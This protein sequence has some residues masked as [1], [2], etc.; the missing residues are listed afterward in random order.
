M[1]KRVLTVKE[2]ADYLHVHQSTIYRMLKRAQLPAFRVG[3]DW[4]FNI[5][6]IDRW[7]LQQID[8]H[9]NSIP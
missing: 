5:E 6:N 4:R 8:R 9:T 2:V 1:S 7:R 3:S